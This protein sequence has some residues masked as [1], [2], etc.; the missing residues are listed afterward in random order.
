MLLA[1]E[2]LPEHRRQYITVMIIHFSKG[3]NI[4][5]AFVWSYIDETL[6]GGCP[7]LVH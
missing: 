3:T 2:V 7:R 1:G 5:Y 4:H 6:Y